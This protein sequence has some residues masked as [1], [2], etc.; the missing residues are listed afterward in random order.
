LVG[1]GASQTSW[2]RLPQA[3][4]AAAYAE[5][6]HA[7]QRRSDGTP[8]IRHPREVATL[9]YDAGAT[10]DVIAA[11]LLH[12]LVEK[13]DVSASELRGRFGPE[14]TRV[15]LAVTDD[16]RIEGYA[17]RKAALRHQVA[18]A[19]TQALTVFAADKLSKLRELRR[20]TAGDPGGRIRGS[21]ARRLRHY[22]R[23]LALLQERLPESPLVLDLR[24]ELGTLLRERPTS[25]P[26]PEQLRT[27][28]T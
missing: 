21:R 9:L 4:S 25:P 8:F 5:S 28:D 24:D 17:A 2:E 23:S 27:A 20:A 6:K 13:A 7:G 15:V 18:G 10:E 22:Q 26:V 16:A 19:G 11:G 1:R 12:D 3:R 14:V